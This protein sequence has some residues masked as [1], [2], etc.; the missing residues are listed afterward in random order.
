LHKRFAQQ[1]NSDVPLRRSI[2]KEGIDQESLETARQKYSNIVRQQAKSQSNQTME[3]LEAH[4]HTQFPWAEIKSIHKQFLFLCDG[5]TEP[6]IPLPTF[7]KVVQH[8]F[9]KWTNDDFTAILFKV[10][11]ENKDNHLDF[12]ELIYGL[13][14]L[15]KGQVRQ[16]VF[17]I[18]KMCDP[19]NKGFIT[20]K[21]FS[22]FL[23]LIYKMYFPDVDT[24][25]EVK[26]YVDMIFEMVD[27]NSSLL[28]LNE[29]KE[30]VFIQPVIVKCF[31]LENTA[32]LSKVMIVPKMLNIV[33][34]TNGEGSPKTP[35]KVNDV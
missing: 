15:C 35:R 22:D 32:P 4:M 26:V 7:I 13:N 28:T 8:V 34:E 25:D 29:F 21:H 19:E 18:Y 20:K 6:K 9:P 24:R 33:K 10:L 5:S 3:L 17:L 30:A 23:E 14:I 11:D 2:L 1:F 27:Q 31:Q 12:Q 16:K